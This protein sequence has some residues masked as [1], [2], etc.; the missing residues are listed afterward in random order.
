MNQKRPLLRRI[1]PSLPLT[2]MVIVFWL[3]LQFS[4][5]M[6]VTGRSFGRSATGGRGDGRG[7]RCASLAA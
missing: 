7:A 6:R 2:V 1:F 5:A 4:R 3:L